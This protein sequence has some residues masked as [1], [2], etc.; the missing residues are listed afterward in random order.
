MNKLLLMLLAGVFF[1]GQIAAQEKVIHGKVTTID[2]IPLIGV[3]IRVNSTKKV[4]YSD[5]LGRFT[6]LCA[7]RDKV[8]FIARGFA[9]KQVKTDEMTNYIFLNLKIKPGPE[10]TSL[11]STYVPEQHRYRLYTGRGLYEGGEDFS[12]YDDIYDIIRA[13]IP[14]VEISPSREILIRGSQTFLGSDAAL[15]VVDDVIVDQ[16][17]FEN[18][19]PSD[20]SGIHV[21]KGADASGYG[22]RGAN[23][24]IIVRTKR[25]Q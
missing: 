21:L 24:V 1:P 7:A 8:K 22:S 6:V 2:S 5:T 11:A 16:R 23:G 19:Q 3:S 17:Y 15:L 10:Y 14:G 9:N 13:R 25:G 18:L 12:M 4:V 20:I